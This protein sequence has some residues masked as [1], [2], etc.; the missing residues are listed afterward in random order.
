MASACEGHVVCTR[1]LG[2][3][4]RL[5]DGSRVQT[6]VVSYTANPLTWMQTKTGERFGNFGLEN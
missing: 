5:P 6:I 3:A 2:E 1:Q 4:G